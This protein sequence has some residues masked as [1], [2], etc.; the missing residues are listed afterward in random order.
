MRVK[1]VANPMTFSHFSSCS[2]APPLENRHL[3][4]TALVAAIATTNHVHTIIKIEPH[5]HKINSKP[6]YS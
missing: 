3:W 6:S 5:V 4:P 2:S 1:E